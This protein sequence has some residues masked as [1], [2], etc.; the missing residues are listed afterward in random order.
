MRE[1]DVCCLIR[2]S[3]QPINLDPERLDHF[4]LV[5]H[6]YRQYNSQAAMK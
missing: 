4:G 3:R 5:L 6:V 1:E 2:G